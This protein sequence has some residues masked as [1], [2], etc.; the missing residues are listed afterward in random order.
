MG[1]CID[2]LPGKT[3]RHCCWSPWEQRGEWAPSACPAQSRA[4]WFFL[5]I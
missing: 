5:S 2:T 3:P 1:L 4:V